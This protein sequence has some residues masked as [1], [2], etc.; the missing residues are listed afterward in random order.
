MKRILIAAG[1]GVAAVSAVTAS[2]ASLGGVTASSLGADSAIVASCDTDGI[3]VDYAVTYSAGVYKVTDVKLS[4][5]NAACNSL[6]YSVSLA[7]G[8]NAS[9]VNAS[10]T[11]SVTAGAASLAV[12]PV[13]ANSV[14]LGSLVISG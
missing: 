5:V 13:S 6:K 2:A 3:G 7:D 9:L 14:Q 10:G 1:A 8:T 12:T 11:L 4:G